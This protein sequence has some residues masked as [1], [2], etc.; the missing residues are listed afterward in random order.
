LFLP[1]P[2]NTAL[3]RHAIFA[4]AVSVV[5]LCA[6]APAAIA[7]PNP[8]FTV[9]PAQPRCNDSATFTDN[10]T[11]DP[12]LAVAKVEWDFDNDG[13]YEVVN[14]MAPFQAAHTYRSR[15]PQTFGM[16]VTDNAP[17]MPGVMEE[18]QTVNVVTGTP[19]ATFSVSDPTPVVNS[20]ILF[21]SDASDPDGDALSYA[22]DFDDDGTTDSTERN[23][24]HRYTTPGAKHAVLTVTDSCGATSAPA[25]RDVTVSGPAVPGNNNPVANFA[26]VPRTVQVG[27]PVS[28]VSSSF[29][30][31][32][33]LRDESWD[34][35]GDGQ[36]DDARGSEVV[37]T[38]T[39][40]GNRTVRLKVT[41]SAGVSEVR[42]RLLHVDPAP[43]P[44][45][46]S[47][48]PAP[49]IRFNGLVL[50]GGARVRILGV[51]APRGALVA[52]QC[53]GRGCPAKQRRKRVKTHSVRF[54]T[55]ERF[56]RAGIQLDIYIRKPSTIGAFT[57]YKIRAGKGPVRLQRCLP[58]GSNTKPKRRCG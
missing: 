9:D 47:L 45:P 22:W 37:Y 43:K 51:R 56:L 39:K 41:D 54:K 44:P 29:D 23:P 30:V 40:A 53:K 58:P 10:S 28:F 20:E 8:A 50:S 13:V 57:R 33:P 26:F 6:F 14:A 7:A 1:A 11:A 3:R 31:D 2:S 42:E 4:L 18:D 16:R 27:D 15:G 49:F 48:R 46:G 12:L 34:L 5:L 17:L 52:V 25:E 32:G 21:A 55:Y 35:D 24:I 19:Q 36:F 38:Y